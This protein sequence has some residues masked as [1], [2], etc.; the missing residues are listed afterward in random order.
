MLVVDGSADEMIAQLIGAGWVL[1]EG[2][3]VVHGKRIRMM[4]PP[5]GK[6]GEEGEVAAT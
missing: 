1:E 6:E 5:A 2:V 3:E 4:R